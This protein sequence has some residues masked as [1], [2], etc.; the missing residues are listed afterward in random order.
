M[1]HDKK[2]DKKYL[3]TIKLKQYNEKRQKMKRQGLAED[4]NTEIL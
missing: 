2:K 3:K 4:N 1:K